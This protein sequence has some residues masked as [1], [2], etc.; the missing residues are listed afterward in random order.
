MGG[1][2]MSDAAPPKA[3][4][5]QN[6]VTKPPPS[7]VQK[8][9]ADEQPRKPRDEQQRNSRGEQPRKPR[10]EQQRN[11]RGEQPRKPRDEQPRKPR[12][13]QPRNS[14][15]EQPRNDRDGQPRSQR[16]DL[17]DRERRGR[18]DIGDRDRDRRESRGRR[19]DDRS[20]RDR[21]RP[22]RRSRSPGDRFRR[23]G[24][25][26]GGP[27][28]GRGGPDRDRGGQDRG[29]SGYGDRDS[30]GY[31]RRERFDDRDSGYGGR[32]RSRS[33]PR[34]RKKPSAWDINENNEKIIIDPTLT[35]Q[36]QAVQQQQTAALMQQRM[37]LL[38]ANQS[39]MVN[40][41]RNRIYIGSISFELQ[42]AE[43]RSAFEPFGKIMSMDMPLEFPGRSKG[44]CFIEFE[45]GD[46]AERAIETMNGF[47]LHG[48]QIKVGRP[49]ALQRTAAPQNILNAGLG[50]MSTGGMSTGVMSENAQN[51]QDQVRHAIEMTRSG[52]QP[53][54]AA[55]NRRV[56]VGSIAWELQSENIKQVFEAFGQ[57][58][59]CQLI[60]NPETG[61][62]KG[63][64]FV[65][66]A[67]EQS[68]RDAVNN[69]NGFELCGRQLKV[70]PAKSG[71]A[72]PPMPNRPNMQHNQMMAAAPPVPAGLPPPVAMPPALPRAG[73]AP[74]HQPMALPPPTGN[75]KLDRMIGEVAHFGGP[76]CCL[77]LFNMVTPE[78]V[79]EGL[80]GEVREE[81]SQY[82]QV[83]SVVC[84]VSDPNA[85]RG[86]TS[87]VQIYVLFTQVDSAQRAMAGLDQRMFGGQV[88]TA[89]LFDEGR[90]SMR[91]F[92]Q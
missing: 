73:A 70:G 22:R 43:V 7:D 74:Q 28:R 76:S 87:A 42:E 6:N 38:Q 81:C 69:M 36:Q 20:F 57:V 30:G 83:D 4:E 56:Y 24:P 80:R 86:D 51:V 63:Y 8:T 25:D 27:D 61:Q 9:A 5:V 66:F 39:S 54:A 46:D 48:R 53:N 35:K 3:L 60:P 23:G 44:F 64:G 14:R 21:D 47:T 34:R 45:D 77:V 33:P 82:G 32:D 11:S 67:N 58:L 17:G 85:S 65:E 92:L 16:A 1:E 91:Q 29:R 2:T 90:Y 52:V 13:E 75:Q 40:R 10:D 68:A 89:R 78:E 15:D 41:Q 84:H 37:L 59:S 72:A 55:A 31:G 71:T 88:V 79:D 19:D 26:R 18:G 50:G 49:T 62:H 12:D